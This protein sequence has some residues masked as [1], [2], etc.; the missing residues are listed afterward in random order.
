MPP[1]LLDQ[2]WDLPYDT[3]S[4]AC[5]LLM[6]IT[7]I[8]VLQAWVPKNSAFFQRGQSHALTNDQVNAY[9][10]LSVACPTQCATDTLWAWQRDQYMS[11]HQASNWIRCQNCEEDNIKGGLVHKRNRHRYH[12]YGAAL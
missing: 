3:I 5:E 10:S 4:L 2:N 8:V 12:P 6:K 7:P 1:W 11:L 9:Y